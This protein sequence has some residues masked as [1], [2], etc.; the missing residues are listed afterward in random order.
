MEGQDQESLV[1]FRLVLLSALVP[2]VRL[3]ER[4]KYQVFLD[5]TKAFTALAVLG[6]KG[7]WG[8]LSLASRK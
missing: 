5:L 4:E 1:G 6:K 2:R 7:G 3:M 8:N